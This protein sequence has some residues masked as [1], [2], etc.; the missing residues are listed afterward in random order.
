MLSLGM[1]V[2]FC[3][4]GYSTDDKEEENSESVRL[5]SITAGRVTKEGGSTGRR[6][7]GYGDENDYETMLHKKSALQ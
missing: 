1:L 2:I 5:I 6:G 4:V 3:I 7:K